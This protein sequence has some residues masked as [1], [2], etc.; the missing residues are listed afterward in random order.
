MI[1]WLT[2]V[3]ELERFDDSFAIPF[4]I[5]AIFTAGG[6]W[7]RSALS[8]NVNT[9]HSSVCRNSPFFYSENKG[10]SCVPT[11]PSPIS[12][13]QDCSKQSLAPL[14]GSVGCAG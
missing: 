6:I 10:C 7:L 2:S 4:F 14:A 8:Q 12:L 13:P 11:C 3:D 1:R 5:D 9:A